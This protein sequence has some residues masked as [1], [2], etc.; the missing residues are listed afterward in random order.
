MT[1]TPYLHFLIKETEAK[2]GYL[3]LTEWYPALPGDKARSFCRCGTLSVGGFQLEGPRRFLWEGPWRLQ[4]IWLWL[5]V[6][7]TSGWENIWSKPSEVGESRVCCGVP[8]VGFGESGSFLGW[9]W[10]GSFYKDRLQDRLEKW[11]RNECKTS[12][13]IFLLVFCGKWD[14]PPPP[15]CHILIS[16]I[17]H[18]V[19]I[20][21]KMEF[22]EV[23]N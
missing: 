12:E 19:T 16:G 9:S 11:E 21:D 2:R 15:R 3:C 13:G 20:H 6:G 8:S 23:I 7:D 5:R 22:A 14:A 10:P 17:C 4:R 18:H 1:E